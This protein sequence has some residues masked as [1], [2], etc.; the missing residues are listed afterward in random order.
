MC[1]IAGMYG[2]ADRGMVEDMVQCLEHRGPDGDG[3]YE[4]DGIAMGM[5]RLAII[6]PEGGDQPIHNEEET[7]WVVFN[8]EI[9]NYPELRKELEADGHEFYTDADTEVLVHLYEEHGPGFVE[10][11][12]GM[13]AFALWDAESEQLL[14]A[15]DRL[16]IKPL[17]YAEHD[18]TFRFGSELKAL[19]RSGVPADPSE[20]GLSYYWQLD[21]IPAPHTAFEGMRKLEPGHLMVVDENG[22]RRT[23]YWDFRDETP[24][25]AD[26]AFYRDRLRDLLEDSVERRMLADVPLGAFLSGGIDSST[27]A[28]LMSQFSD[29]PVRTFSIGFADAEHDETEYAR[30]AAEA[31]GADHTEYTVELSDAS[32]VPEALRS[33]DEP[34]S[35]PASIPTHL[36]AQRASQEVTV[37]NTGS[38]ADELF[39]GYHRYL[40][41]VKYWNRFRYIPVP[42]KRLAGIAAELFPEHTKPWRY[43]GYLGSMTS[44]EDAYTERR[45]SGD[46]GFQGDDPN[47]H[48]LVSSSMRDGRDYLANMTAFDI[49][50]WLPD[51][52]L[53]KVDRTTMANGLEARV[54]FLDHR[55]VEFSRAVPSRYKIKNGTEK[56][57]LRQAVKD[58]LPRDILHREKKGFSVP[59]ET[60]MR[61]PDSP[62]AQRFD[63]ERF[64][65]VPFLDADTITDRYERFTRGDNRYSRMMWKALNL[66]VWTK[67]Y[68]KS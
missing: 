64:E 61:D 14:L 10:R 4:D 35:D 8:G 43:L 57:L 3:F 31:F 41:D 16:G 55:L 22:A 46:N 42:A 32:I 50:Y 30:T 68:L 26:E 47:I 12:N 39:G 40:T 62:V 49:R 38:G 18:D 56:Y 60:W 63:Q 21:Y 2:E 58:I 54:P 53:V 52:L 34:L 37:V 36:I 20:T 13:F 5:R 65:A 67:N 45:A 48:S 66:E 19:L 59:I 44:M 7:V 17:Y 33:F 1:G 9:Y 23:A 24:G 29:E 15:R 25:D 6:D 27:V 11:L 28:G 51:D